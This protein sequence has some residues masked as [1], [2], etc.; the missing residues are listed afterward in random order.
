METAAAIKDYIRRE[1]LGGSSEVELGDDRPLLR[2]EIL[3]SLGVLMLVGFLEDHLGVA[4][5]PEEVTVA[6][7]QTVASIVRLVESKGPT[8]G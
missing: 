5:D 4:I 8:S 3:D 2:D 6:N 7:F 1:F